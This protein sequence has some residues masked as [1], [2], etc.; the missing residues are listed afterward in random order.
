MKVFYSPEY[1]GSTHGFDTTRKAFHV[2]EAA[3]RIATLTAPDTTFNL[4]RIH[5]DEYVTAVETGEPIHMAESQGFPWDETI[6]PMAQAHTDG[7]VS[8][9]DDVLGRGRGRSGSLS[10]GLHHAATSLGGGFCTY[11]GLA[12]AAT[13]AFDHGC[14]RVL[15]LDFDAHC[16]GGTYDILSNDPRW[17][18]I[19]V[20]VSAFDQYRAEGRHLLTVTT[21]RDYMTEIVAALEVAAAESWDFII[22][23]AGVDPINCGVDNRTLHLREFVTSEMIGDTP[24]V[25]A[26][27][28]GYTWGGVTM[29]ELVE[30]HCST[31]TAWSDHEETATWFSGDWY[32]G[33]FSESTG[34]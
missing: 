14:E 3:G 19:D 27:A 20:S 25:F 2:A 1:C 31:I 6:A 26:L 11:N 24:A 13:R 28:G 16:G 8:A 23:N 12:A 34:L 9:V 30:L 10:S 17:T 15:C 7:L 22:Y 29:D 21:P 18:Q 33:A 4:R 5:S 32:N